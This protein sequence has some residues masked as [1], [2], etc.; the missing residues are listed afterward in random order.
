LGWFECFRFISF[1]SS[2][3]LW[4]QKKGTEGPFLGLQGFPLFSSIRNRSSLS[5]K[6]LEPRGRRA[7]LA[8][9]AHEL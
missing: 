3:E 8:T 2:F 9:L 1:C 5:Q 6:G 7:T 4:E